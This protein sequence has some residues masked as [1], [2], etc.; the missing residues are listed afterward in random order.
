MVG[1]GGKTH[2]YLWLEPEGKPTNRKKIMGGEKK[3]L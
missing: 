2:K 1:A 3:I